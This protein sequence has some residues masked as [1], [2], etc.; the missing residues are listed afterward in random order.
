[1]CT[2]K[3]AAGRGVRIWYV[4]SAYVLSGPDLLHD[5]HEKREMTADRRSV[6]QIEPDLLHRLVG[7]ERL[8]QDLLP[9][10]LEAYAWYRKVGAGM[11][12]NQALLEAEACADAIRARVW[13][14]CSPVLWPPISTGWIAHI[15]AFLPFNPWDEIYG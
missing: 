6:W 10:A 15:T 12:K 5:P 2:A 9:V 13:R 3:R 8:L 11:D 14:Y 4:R 1:M 7:T